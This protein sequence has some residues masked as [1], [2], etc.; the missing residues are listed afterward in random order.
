ML[1]VVN[2]RPLSYPVLSE[3]CRRG[4]ACAVYEPRPV[5][6]F[7]HAPLGLS[8]PAPPA[9]SPPRAP[10]PRVGLHLKPGQK[11][12]KQLLAQYGDRLI[13]VRYRYDAER[14]K[15]LKTVELLVAERDSEPPRP[16]LPDD[17]LVALRIA[18]ADV[19][20]RTRVKQ[21][22]GRW[23]A[24]RRVWQLRYDRAVAL[25]LNNRIVNESPS[26]GGCPAS[27]RQHLH[28]DAPPTST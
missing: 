20:I 28:A 3:G 8:A 16:R 25:G 27:N 11:G 18:F 9:P 21:A 2:K 7:H 10:A 19:A 6:P 22:G 4:S 15:R 5:D 17:Q 13:C 26:N 24:E 1:I 12:T 14:R 23:D